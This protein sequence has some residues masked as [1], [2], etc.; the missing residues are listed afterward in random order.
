MGKECAQALPSIAE[1]AEPFMAWLETPLADIMIR[2]PITAEE[3]DTVRTVQA[4]M[5]HSGAGHLPVLRDERPVGIV[6]ARD[7]AR[8]MP[9]PITI[10]R[11]AEMGR[12]LE[13][14]VTE[15]MSAPAITLPTDATVEAAVKLMVDA[16]IGAI[17]VVDPE[18]GRLAGLI[19]RSTITGL[20]AARNG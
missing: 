19:T 7:L 15:V 1:A 12:L 5:H 11:R 17:V 2:H 10:L 13:L 18:D 4:R 14:A 3:T 9:V 16:G 6:T 20:V 8:S